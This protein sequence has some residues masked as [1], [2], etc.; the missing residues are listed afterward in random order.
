MHDMVHSQHIL[1]LVGSYYAFVL[2]IIMSIRILERWSLYFNYLC[3]LRELSQ[4]EF[5]IEDMQSAH[6]VNV[7]L[8]I[9][10]QHCNIYQDNNK[11]LTEC[12]LVLQK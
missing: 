7:V 5:P 2:H 6:I 3:D 12:L 9:L 11:K 4:A 1:N 10:I 8:M